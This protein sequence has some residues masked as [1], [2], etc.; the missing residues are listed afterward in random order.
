MKLTR[1]TS[2][3]LP[4]AL[5]ALLIT[6]G[7][8]SNTQPPPQQAQQPDQQSAQPAPNQP[9]QQA[10]NPEATPAPSSEHQRELER[11]RYQEGYAAGQKQA[12]ANNP[13]QQGQSTQQ[14]YAPPPPPRAPSVIPAGTHIVVSLG[15]TISSKT[16]QVGDRF[17]ATVAEP[18]V[19]NGATLIRAGAPATGTVTDAKALGRFKGGAELAL[20]LDEVQAEGR[21]YQVDSSTIDRAEKGKGKRTAVMTGGGGGFGAL[22]GGLAG[23]GKGALIGALAGAGAGGAGSAFTGNKELVITPETSLTFRLERDVPLR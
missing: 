19:V 8:K 13:P 3:T 1:L 6:S 21:R 4:L 20:R 23:G 5:A 17:S 15:Q 2:T 9:A 11:K 16:A 22:I 14:A 18:V 7:C 12:G 10:T